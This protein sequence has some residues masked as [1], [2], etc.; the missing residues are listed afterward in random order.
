MVF[1]LAEIFFFI[2]FI[3]I[4]VYFTVQCTSGCKK[5]F[6]NTNE[7]SVVT[8]TVNL[9]G[10]HNKKVANEI[11]A[12]RPSNCISMQPE[13]IQPAESVR[14]KKEEEIAK[15]IVDDWE[16]S[17]EEIKATGTG[18]LKAN[19]INQK[20]LF[21]PPK[22]ENSYTKKSM[23]LQS[24]KTVNKKITDNNISKKV[25]SNSSKTDSNEDC[26]R[27]Q[28]SKIARTLREEEIARGER[29][30]ISAKDEPT[31]EEVLDD[32]G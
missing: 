28:P 16:P 3:N 23:P 13:I 31:L 26:K 32:W 24:L 8:K 14:T 27:P 5:F 17:I 30:T 4:I 2:L 9:F 25:P 20:R 1:F 15:D 21:K 18:S 6:K 29:K 12:V 19:G 10:A 11:T 22:P 7:P